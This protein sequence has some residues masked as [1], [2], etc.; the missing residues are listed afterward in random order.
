[1]REREE[2]ERDGKRKDPA[3]QGDQETFLIVLS[4]S[5]HEIPESLVVSNSSSHHIERSK[6]LE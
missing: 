4:F 2:R 3:P 1:L 5:D 6:D